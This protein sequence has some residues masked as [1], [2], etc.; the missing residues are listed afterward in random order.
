MT[1]LGIGM[2]GRSEAGWKVCDARNGAY[3][4]RSKRVGEERN[5]CPI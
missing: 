2:E 1:R 5:E 4:G 3:A